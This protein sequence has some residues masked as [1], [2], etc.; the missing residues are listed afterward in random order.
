MKKRITYEWDIETAY[1]YGDCIDHNFADRLEDLKCLFEGD[2]HQ[3]LSDLDGKPEPAH[4]RIVLVRD[5]RF[6]DDGDLDDRQWCYL[7]EDGT[8]PTTF[9]E[10]AKVPVKFQREFEANNWASKFTPISD[11]DRLA[12]L[13]GN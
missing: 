2:P 12:E 8:L 6:V 7:N 4:I 3:F 5:S 1:N 13:I 11:D 9:D 10:G